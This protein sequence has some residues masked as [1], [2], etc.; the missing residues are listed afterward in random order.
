MTI[1]LFLRSFVRKFVNNGINY[2]RNQF[3][4]TAL[5]RIMYKFDYLIREVLLSQS[6]CS[7]RVGEGQRPSEKN[8]K[9]KQ[10][11]NKQV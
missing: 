6:R 3:Y 5:D 9:L 1:S 7:R 11:F 4:K 8:R 2:E 10:Y